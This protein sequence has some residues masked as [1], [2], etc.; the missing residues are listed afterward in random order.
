MNGY[1]CI[2]NNNGRGVCLFYKDSLTVTE[3]HNDLFPCSILCSIKT[4]DNITF[5]LGLVYRSPS[6]TLEENDNMIAFLHSFLSKINPRSDVVLVLGD[7]NLPS[8]N[9][10]HE[11]CPNDSKHVS[12]KFLDCVHEYY[13]TQFVDKPTHHRGEQNPTLID[14][15]L[16]NDNEFV[17]NLNQCAPF[18]LSHHNVISFSLNV[19]QSNVSLPTVT[20]FIWDKGD[21][22]GMNDHLKNVDWD[23]RFKESTDVNSLW[24][25]VEGEILD[26]RD[27]YVPRRTIKRNTITHKNKIPIPQTLLELFHKKRAAF[28]YFKKYPTD[29]NLE[30]YH[31]LRNLA[32]KY[33]NKAKL[34]KE[35]D[36]ANRSK[37]NPKLLYQY[38]ASQS[39]PK[40]TIPN[41]RKPDGTLTETDSDKANVLNSFFASIFVLLLLIRLNIKQHLQI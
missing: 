13:L 19:K 33:S 40:E 4:N 20:K 36:I 38:L 6:S 16:S 8:I 35:I 32:K 3:I 28:R 37:D 17:Y 26:A 25:M 7:F 39:K 24:D 21:Y 14:L 34:D 2:Q 5:T 10:E 22:V 29:Q 15:V 9:W 18:G 11:T 30:I 12:S 41:L 27:K 23:S 1:S 31:S